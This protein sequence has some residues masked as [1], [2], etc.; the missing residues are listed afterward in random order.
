MKHYYLGID[1]GSI[2]TNIAVIDED[3]NI[4][5]SLYIRTQGQPIKAV[6][7]GLKIVYEDLH[8]HNLDGIEIA[9]AGTT[10][11]ARR[12]TGVMI[13]AD[14]V[15]NE[16]IAH[17]VAS[18]HFYPDVRTIIEIGGQDSKIIIIR[19][20]IVVDFAMN[21]VCAAG[22]GSFLDHQAQRLNIPI[23][24]FGKLALESKTKVNIA[25]RCTVFAES[26]MIHKAQLGFATEDIINGLCEAIVRNYLNNVGKGKDISAPI[27]FQGGVAANIG[28]K[29]A[30]EKE[31]GC[32]IIVPK[33][34]HIMG[35]IGVAILAKEYTQGRSSNFVGFDIVNVDFKTRSFECK[36][37]PNHCEV[38]ETYKDNK[39]VDRYG[40]RCGKWELVAR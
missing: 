4:L 8:K 37:C 9:G 40:D 12:L 16:I 24:E 36:G 25:G 17:A 30:F 13:N 2:S 1:V 5:A 18:I 32:E 34:Y 26:D 22:T 29:R 21:T 38:I 10:G 7:Q 23:E 31:L 11:S 6:Q 19:D 28:V 27:L 33:Y 3:V 14:I 20:G 35:A 39:L 15:K